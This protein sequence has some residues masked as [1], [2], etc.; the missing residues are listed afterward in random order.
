MGGGSLPT[1]KWVGVGQE[2]L[3]DTGVR[4]AANGLLL[5]VKSWMECALHESYSY[6]YSYSSSSR[7]TIALHG[8]PWQF[9]GSSSF[10][11]YACLID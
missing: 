6:S 11:T 7:D 2:L 3:P 5:R 1:F 10:G 8:I 4:L 9:Y